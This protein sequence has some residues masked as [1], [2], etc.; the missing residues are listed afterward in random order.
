MG[1]LGAR[2]HA[3]MKI[4]FLGTS[5]AWPTPHPGCECPQCA[6]ARADGRTRRTR[7]SLLLESGDEVVLVDPGPDVFQQF[8][9]EGL[10]PRVDR[11]LVTH[12]HM[13][14]ILGLDDLVNL[15]EDR[16]HVLDVHAAG[17]H[18]RRIAEIFPHLVD[19]K[20]PRVVFEV[21]KPGTELPMEGIR[22]EGF[23]AGHRAYFPTTALLMHIETTEG[24][25]RVAYATDMGDL[26]DD[27]RERLEGIDLLV[28]DGTF[29]GGPGHGHPGTDAVLALAE[30]LEIEKVAFSHIGHVGV[31]DATLGTLLGEGVGLAYDGGDLLDLLP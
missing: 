29:L 11:V 13:D 18:R 8:E 15:R 28:G 22:L 12:C 3:A 7:S 5:A 23:E 1:P 31:D 14:H 24:V 26:P 21:W 16:K 25:R 30:E 6:E 17:Y 4:T 2:I 9:R 10:E 20:E 27:S 19:E